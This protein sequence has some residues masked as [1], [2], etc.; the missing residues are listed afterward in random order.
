VAITAAAAA[1]LDELSGG[2]LSLGFGAGGGL[3][4]YG[5]DRHRPAVAVREAVEVVRRLVAG[6][7]VSYEGR[8][9][10]MRDARLDFPAI[11][12]LPVYIAARGPRLLELAGEVADGAIIGG[13]A[14]DEGLA[15]AKAAIGRGLA[16]A[17]R[18]W[19]ELDLV[20]WLYTCVADDAV[21]ARRAVSRLVTTSLVT[22]RPVL[23][24]LGL[25]LPPALRECLER[26]GWSVAP[27]LVDECAR[28]LSDEALDAF[29][30]AGTPD[31]CARKLAR[32][33]RTGVS[34][35]AMVALPGPGQSVEEIARRLAAE[36]LP[37]V[38]AEVGG[39]VGATG[40]SA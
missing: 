13:F 27:E 18:T 38:R 37:A 31:E 14:S 33:A 3:G 8:H 15:H 35:L 26:S 10:R 29:S 21:A 16:R 25:R 32:I 24:S 34:E 39:Q 11:R 23:D 7:P 40:G 19:A 12:P 30:V 4:A 17:G 2:R 5:V 28:H 36:V 1:S 9:V 6:G 20:A 22:S